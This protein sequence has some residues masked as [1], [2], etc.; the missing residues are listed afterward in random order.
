[1]PSRALGCREN[2]SQTCQN[3]HRSTQSLLFFESLR[4]GHLPGVPLVMLC[5]IW[6]FRAVKLPLESSNP[7]SPKAAPKAGGETNTPVGISE[8]P[9]SS[10]PPPGASMASSTSGHAAAPLESMLTKEPHQLAVLEDALQG[11]QPGWH[12]MEAV[13]PRFFQAHW[14]SSFL[15]APFV[16]TFSNSF[17]GSLDGACGPGVKESETERK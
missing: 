12:I 13:L 2:L 9:S 4:E 15:S 8:W 14:V 1:M 3:P 5:K 16:L 7:P 11:G 10:N 6:N 17:A